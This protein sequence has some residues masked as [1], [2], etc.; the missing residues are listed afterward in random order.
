MLLAG[1]KFWMSMTTYNFHTFVS[2]TRSLDTDY[3]NKPILAH[4][5]IT[6]YFV[7]VNS[8]SKCDK[9]EQITEHVTSIKYH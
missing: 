3:S 7:S 2:Q 8:C 5:N 9:C 1:K 4:T 6:L